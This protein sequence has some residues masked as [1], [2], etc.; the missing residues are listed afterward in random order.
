MMLFFRLEHGLEL[1]KIFLANRLHQQNASNVVLR[2]LY[3]ESMVW[4]P[5]LCQLLDSSNGNQAPVSS[6]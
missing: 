5:W 6:L 4:W 2:N 3:G 1:A